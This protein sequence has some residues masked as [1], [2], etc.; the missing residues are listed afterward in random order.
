MSIG[1][2]K[3]KR[4]MSTI[5]AVSYPARAEA[6]AFRIIEGEAVVLNLDSG[7]Y[8]SLNE[9]G[10]KIWNL[11]DGTHNIKDITAAVCKEFEVE[12]GTAERDIL[13]VMDDLV[14][15][16]LLIIHENPAPAKSD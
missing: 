5:H 7:L 8:Y 4:T 3:V 9:V 15:E 2:A 14:K 6:L 1:A 10:S 12:P 16:E 13:E 11:C